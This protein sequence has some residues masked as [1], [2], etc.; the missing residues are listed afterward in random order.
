[1]QLG[2]LHGSCKKDKGWSRLDPFPQEEPFNDK[3]RFS[4]LKIDNE[5]NISRNSLTASSQNCSHSVEL[6]NVAVLH[7]HQGQLI[8][9]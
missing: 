5:V 1:M 9:P 6:C 8:F 3:E 2:V 4:K 7:R